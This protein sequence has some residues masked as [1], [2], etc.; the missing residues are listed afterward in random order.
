MEEL[1]KHKVFTVAG[2]TYDWEDV[3]R[4][5]KLRGDW[6][7]LESET[8]QGVACFKQEARNGETL[9]PEEV[10]SAARE[11]RYAHNLITAQEVEG[12]LKNW[13]LTVEEW[14]G[15]FRRSRLRQTWSDQLEAIVAAYPVTDTEI[16]RSIKATAVCSGKLK[17]F[18][19]RLAGRVAAHD[20]LTGETTTGRWLADTNN[21]ERKIAAIAA[22][23]ASFERFRSLVT[24][25]KAVEDRIASQ[26]IEWAWFDCCFVA[27]PEEHLAR[28]AALCVREDGL[29]LHEVA[30]DAKRTV[31]QNSFYLE[32][33][34]AVLKSHL[35]GASKEELIGPVN[36]GGQY[37]LFLV[38][39]K[40]IPSDKD[41]TI[42]QRAEQALLKSALAHEI[43]NRV[44]W[45]V[46]L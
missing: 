30:A 20:K 6:R 45:H 10:A 13:G 7:G 33:A 22:M 35:L 23:E 46:R 27:F 8:R 3:V 25:P 11:F 42:R 36:S 40:Q 9:D 31:Q 16:A 17:Q 29:E 14:M 41:V 37:L 15:Y 12:W 4:A 43:N 44:Q 26:R 24:T 1:F 34:E 19:Q 32:E 18:A 2:T 38:L 21:G 5:A 39:D 28:E